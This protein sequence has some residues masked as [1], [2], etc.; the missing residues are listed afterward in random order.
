MLKYC[1]QLWCSFQ[2]KTLMLTQQFNNCFWYQEDL[3]QSTLHIPIWVLFSDVLW[4]INMTPIRWYNGC[5]W[6]ATMD[7]LSKFWHADEFWSEF[8]SLTKFGLPMKYWR[9]QHC[10]RYQRGRIHW[11]AKRSPAFLAAWPKVAKLRGR[12]LIVARIPIFFA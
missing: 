5:V 9:Y 4:S 6:F 3:F 8:S 12:S 10:L 2:R 11:R 7:Y 1:F